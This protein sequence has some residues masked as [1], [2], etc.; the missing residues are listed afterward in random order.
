[1]SGCRDS[2]ET[3]NGVPRVHVR[4]LGDREPELVAFIEHGIE[5]EGVSWVVQSGFE[6]DVVAIAHEAA[7]ASSLDIGVCVTANSRAVVHHKRLADDD[8]I[9]DV[10]DA[11]PERARRLGSNA[12][13]LAKGTPLKPIP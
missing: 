6:D 13:R 9:F 12:A 2:V 11:A 10:S 1:M 7:V 4:C 3:D 8:P 5:E